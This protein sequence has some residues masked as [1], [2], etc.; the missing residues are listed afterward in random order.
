MIMNFCAEHI[1]TMMHVMSW[2]PLRFED[3]PRLALLLLEADPAD[4]WEDSG[5]PDHRTIQ[6]STL[7]AA[8]TKHQEIR[9]GKRA[10][11]TGRCEGEPSFGQYCC[12]FC[13]VSR[14]SRCFRAA[15]A[16]S[17]VA[18]ALVV[19]KLAESQNCDQG[20]F[21]VIYVCVCWHLM[22]ITHP[23]EGRQAA[24]IQKQVRWRLEGTRAPL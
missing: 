16:C 8:C 21:G 10:C 24:N 1:A 17:H 19:Q 14:R 23:V 13:L 9:I 3:E 7:V 20:T 15:R 12:A 2:A 4:I 22:L 6:M 18:R 5:V 11:H